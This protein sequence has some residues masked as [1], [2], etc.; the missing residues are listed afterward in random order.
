MIYADILTDDEAADLSPWDLTDADGFPLDLTDAVGAEDEDDPIEDL[1]VVVEDL[2]YP[3][4]WDD[5]NP[6]VTSAFLFS[7][8]T[9]FGDPDDNQDDD[10]LRFFG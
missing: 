5:L 4:Q 6:Y 3:A 1:D 10:E 9:R 8:P 7:D 2:A